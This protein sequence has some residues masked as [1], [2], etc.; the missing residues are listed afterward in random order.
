MKQWD[1]RELRDGLESALQTLVVDEPT[2]QAIR[3]ILVQNMVDGR[4]LKHVEQKTGSSPHTY[5]EIVATY[6]SQYALFMDALRQGDSTAIEAM[7]PELHM[8]IR[9][10]FLRWGVWFNP[11]ELEDSI[12]DIG[13]DIVLYLMAKP[14]HYECPPL[15][16]AY[17]IVVNMCKRVV[18]ESI[19]QS[20]W[21]LISW[22]TEDEYLTNL[23]DDDPTPDEQ[24]EL[25]DLQQAIAQLTEKRQIFVELYYDDG[26]DYATIAKM[27]SVKPNSLHKLKSDT[28]K[29]LGKIY[30]DSY[31]M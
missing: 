14:F 17:G 25:L 20:R 30:G 19:R 9:T 22:D 27:L 28:L 12:N 31:H 13:T 7:L 15:A 8:A 18:R 24:V 1:L 29:Q 5:V 4:V 2:R 26:H 11:Q 16:W 3:A 10:T 23:D 21:G 6:Y